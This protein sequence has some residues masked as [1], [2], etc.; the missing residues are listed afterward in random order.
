MRDTKRVF[1]KNMLRLFFKELN[2]LS[3]VLAVGKDQ[4]YRNVDDDNNNNNNYNYYYYYYC[5]CN[6]ESHNKSLCHVIV[7]Q[8]RLMQMLDFKQEI[9]MQAT[10]VSIFSFILFDQ[11]MHDIC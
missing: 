7:T 9:Y 6:L 11:K 5:C 4:V 3:S 8:K 2:T 1:K 10:N